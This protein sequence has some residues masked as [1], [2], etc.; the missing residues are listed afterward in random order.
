MPINDPIKLVATL[1][2]LMQW[3]MSLGKGRDQAFRTVLIGFDEEHMPEGAQTASY[4]SF[5]SV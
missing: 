2:W 3:R 4:H 1:H 5:C